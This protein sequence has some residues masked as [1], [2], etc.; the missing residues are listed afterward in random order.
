MKGTCY[1]HAKYNAEEAAHEKTAVGCGT[2]YRAVTN[3]A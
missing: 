1:E 2:P 3:D